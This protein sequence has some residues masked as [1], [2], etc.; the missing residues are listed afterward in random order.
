MACKTRNRKRPVWLA[1]GLFGGKS[2]R[3]TPGKCPSA[4]SV[5]PHEK[6]G[7]SAVARTVHPKQLKCGG[8]I[9]LAGKSHIGQYRKERLRGSGPTSGIGLAGWPMQSRNGIKKSVRICPY[10]GAWS[11][12]PTFRPRSVEDHTRGRIVGAGGG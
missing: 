9:D 1:Y 2:C 11:M 5:Q 10:A 4:N 6:L 7:L 12:L 8:W 3:M